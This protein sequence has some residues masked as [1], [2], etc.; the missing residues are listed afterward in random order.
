MTFLSYRQ[1][2]AVS[3]M[4]DLCPTG[5]PVIA[6]DVHIYMNNEF[7]YA[8][9]QKAILNEVTLRCTLFAEQ[10]VTQ[11]PCR[12]GCQVEACESGRSVKETYKCGWS[13]P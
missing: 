7:G 12:S 10:C 9:E 6:W 5:L 8:T 3:G 13:E 11:E 2:A 4:L 1:A